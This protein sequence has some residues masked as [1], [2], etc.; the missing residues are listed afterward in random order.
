MSS[1]SRRTS[2]CFSWMS[3]NQSTS[4]SSS[5]PSASQVLTEARAGKDAMAAPTLGKRL[6]PPESPPP[7]AKPPTAPTPFTPPRSFSSSRTPRCSRASSWRSMVSISPWIS[8]SGMYWSDWTCPTAP[9]HLRSARP[10]VCLPPG[11]SLWPVLASQALSHTPCP[12]SQ[13]HQACP[14]GDTTFCLSWQLPPLLW[15][16]RKDIII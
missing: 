16:S 6:P 2:R 12:G 14:E 4:M 8:S 1:D 7:P 11:A 10:P 15:H 3:L 13:C 5:R 9:S